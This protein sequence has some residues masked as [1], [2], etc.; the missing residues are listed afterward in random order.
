M[1]TDSKTSRIIISIIHLV[2]V[3][4]QVFHTDELCGKQFCEPKNAKAVFV[5]TTAHSSWTI[6]VTCQLL[7]VCQALIKDKGIF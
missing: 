3:I 7:S 1:D 5:L 6:G 4:A 2:L